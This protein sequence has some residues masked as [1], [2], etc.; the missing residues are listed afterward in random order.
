MRVLLQ[1]SEEI[2]GAGFGTLAHHQRQRHETPRH[3]GLKHR[4]V[5]RNHRDPAVFLPQ[6]EGRALG[7]VDLQAARIK[8]L[9]GGVG[10]P[11]VG[12][13]LVARGRGVKKQQRRATGYAADGENLVLR[14]LFA[15]GDRDAGDSEADG[16][17]R[18]VA[19]VAQRPEH[20]VGVTALDHAQHGGA[21]Q[22]HGG[23]EQSEAA[24]TPALQHGDP[25]R[26]FVS[27]DV[28]GVRTA[29]RTLR[30]GARTLGC[31]SAPRLRIRLGP[32]RSHRSREASSTIHC[33]NSSNVTPA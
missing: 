31:G 10:N 17:G 7:D 12:L 16:I 9:H 19:G 29:S 14:K 28:C 23:R 30:A 6:R 33:T 20:F 18:S 21:D 2:L 3:I 5:G 11:R 32:L 1:Q 22:H 25:L 24:R 26:L 15:A 13:Q 27:G 8:L 4:S